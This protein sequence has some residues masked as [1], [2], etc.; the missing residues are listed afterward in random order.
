M[1]ANQGLAIVHHGHRIRLKWHQLRK[2]TSDPVF[3]LTVL[4]EG[5]EIGASLELDLRKRSDHGFVVLHDDVLD[6]ETDGVGP[7]A[8][9]DR[10]RLAQVCYRASGLPVIT[11]EALAEHLGDAHPDTV[12]QLDLKDTLSVIGED[13]LR[14]IAAIAGT[15]AKKLIIS[16]L[17]LAL[18]DA[19]HD[20]IP[21]LPRGIDP[22]GDMMQA[23]EQGGMPAA[24]SVLERALAAPNDAGTVYLHWPMILEAETAGLDLIARCHEAGTL[25][26]A[27]TFNMEDPSAGFSDSEWASFRRLIDLKP[28]QIT[29]DQA[30]A[31]E[32]A[33]RQ[34]APA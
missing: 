34:R 15:H 7:V 11:S 6:A 29:T 21:G 18:I 23:A 25:V 8:D 20:V 14:H 31:I 1:S 28:D 26:D 22:T 16:S 10:D 4:H 9:M 13:G 33:W 24:L 2:S 12:L 19:A 3:D 30:P 17:D 27:W 5:F 32:R